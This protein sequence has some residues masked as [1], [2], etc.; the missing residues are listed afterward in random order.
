VNKHWYK[1]AMIYELSVKA[2]KDNNKDG[3]GDFEGLISKLDYLKTLGINCIWLLPIYPSPMRDD[4]YDI[5]D[6][7]AIHKDLGDIEDFKRFIKEAHKRKIKVI[8]ELVLNH[9]SDQHQWFIEACKG[10]DSPYHDY[11]IWSDTPDQYPDA[12]IIFVDTESSNWSY[13]NQAKKYYMHRFYSHQPDLNYGNPKVLDEIKN[14]ISYWLDLGVDGFRFDAVA[15]ICKA[16]GTTCENLPQAHEVIKEL[17]RF[18]DEKAPNIVLLA[19]VNQWPED[20]VAYFGNGDEFQ[21]AYNFP[22]MPRMFM[23]IEQEHHGPIVD[24]M[25]QLPSIPENC[26]WATFLRN[27]DELTLEMCTDEER[28]Y[29]Y[30]AYAEDDLMKL[31]VGIRRRLSPLLDNDQKK[32]E[33]LYFLLFTLP[34]APIIYYGDEIG[35]GDNIHLGDRNGVRTPMHWHDGKNAGFSDCNPSKL[36]APVISDPEYHYSTVNVEVQKNRPSSIFNFL[37]RLIAIR[38]SNPLFADGELEFLYPENKKV[39]VFLRKGKTR[40]Y[41]VVI[42]FSSAPQPVEIILEAYNGKSVKELLG[43]TLFPSIGE[44]PYFITLNAYGYYMF[45]YL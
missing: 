10:E 14:V 11:Y 19:E 7:Y 40:T 44:L 18:I 5:Q 29:M 25:K 16:E 26:Q 39:L 23:A 17:R 3:K 28:D 6:Y 42:N 34:G 32:I 33:L 43:D 4:G 1:N 9:T 12:R 41:M 37:K 21:M 30:K 38:K 45:E 31:N 22:L 15:H 36:Y 13:H 24:I 2:F 8:T 20:L 35:M 27:H